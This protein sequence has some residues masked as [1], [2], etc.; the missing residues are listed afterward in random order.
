MGLLRD[1][2][3]L[4]EKMAGVFAGSYRIKIPPVRI[5]YMP[6]M[7]NK[8]IW[9]RAIGHRGDVYKGGRWK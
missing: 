1:N 9:I 6:D 5:I 7:K 4:G 2:P 3:L 8:I